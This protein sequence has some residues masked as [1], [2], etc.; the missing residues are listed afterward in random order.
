MWILKIFLV[1]MMSSFFFSGC[2][3]EWKDVLLDRYIHENATL[4]KMSVDQA[5]VGML[6]N[7]SGTPSAPTN[8]YWDSS[9]FTNRSSYQQG[10]TTAIN[11]SR[12]GRGRGK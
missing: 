12:I 11:N 6:P 8:W 3:R 9:Y 7:F 1:A 5:N 2:A 4:G 10:I